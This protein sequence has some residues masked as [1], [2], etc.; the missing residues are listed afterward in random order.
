MVLAVF[1]LLPVAALETLRYV[2]GS[3]VRPHPLAYLIPFVIHLLVLSGG[4]ATGSF[5]RAIPAA[6][7]ALVYFWGSL[8]A[9]DRDGVPGILGHQL[10]EVFRWVAPPLGGLFRAAVPFHT[11]STVL[12][13]VAL[14]VQATAWIGIFCA[15]TIW[16]Y[17]RD[18]FGTRTW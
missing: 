3:P 7:V 18:E 13:D 11:P 12:D 17:Q 15:I 1:S 5:C 14:L 6:F 2:V 10:S 16:R 8:F 9:E 4:M